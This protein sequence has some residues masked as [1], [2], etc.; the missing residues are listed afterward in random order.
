MGVCD[1]RALPCPALAL[2]VTRESTAWGTPVIFAC[3]AENADQQQKQDAFFKN[4]FAPKT[5]PK[6]A[7][8]LETDKKPHDFPTL[9]GRYSVRVPC[10]PVPSV[11]GNCAC[12]FRL[13]LAG[14][15]PD[16][17]GRRG[18]SRPRNT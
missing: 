3:P 16:F 12:L 10:F 6:T 9:L 5:A 15:G 18:L 14:F 7:Q 17:E 1:N 4:A 8:S 2:P 13:A 11:G